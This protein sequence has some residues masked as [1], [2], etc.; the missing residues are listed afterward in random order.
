MLP[1]DCPSR[2]MTEDRGDRYRR[3]GYSGCSF[4]PIGRIAVLVKD[5]RY[6]LLG[7]EL[8]RLGLTKSV[9]NALDSPALVIQEFGHSLFGQLG[10]RTARVRGQLVKFGCEVGAKRYRA[11]GHRITYLTFGSITVFHATR[12]RAPSCGSFA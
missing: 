11:V 1:P 5:G 7:G 3:G 2:Y 4:R 9:L 10:T 6:L 8:S 12:N